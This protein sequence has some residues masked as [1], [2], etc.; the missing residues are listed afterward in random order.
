MLMHMAKMIDRR[1]DLSLRNGRENYVVCEISRLSRWG[2]AT[3]GLNSYE[4]F[5]GVIDCGEES[6]IYL[7]GPRAVG[8]LAN[9]GR[10]KLPDRL[11]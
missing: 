11:N 5:K 9:Y 8:A 1:G 4:S 10:D 6:T 7:R 2:A 3:T